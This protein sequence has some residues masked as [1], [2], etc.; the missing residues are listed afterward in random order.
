MNLTCSYVA[1]VKDGYEYG[2]EEYDLKSE[3]RV[4]TPRGVAPTL[5][6]A[7]EKSNMSPLEK[8]IKC[9]GKPSPQSYERPSR[10]IALQQRLA[11]PYLSVSESTTL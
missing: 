3:D 1:A 5:E 9:S 11:Q 4:R 10:F 2:T 8:E 7:L 6:E